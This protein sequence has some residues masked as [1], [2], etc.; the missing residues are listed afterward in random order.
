MIHLTNK[1]QPDYSAMLAERVR[2]IRKQ[3]GLSQERLA[4]RSGVSLGSL[5]RFE[6]TH[7]ISLTSFIKLLMAL[8]RD[9]ELDHL[10]A[11]REYTSI[12]EVIADA[13]RNLREHH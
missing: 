6:R 3:K 4:E 5:K 7:E 1:L 2:A 12:Q 8:G 9:A 10:L 11:E 13:E